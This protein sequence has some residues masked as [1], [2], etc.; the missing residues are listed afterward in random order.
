MEQ[1]LVGFIL[2]AIGGLNVVRPDI[3]LR[4]QV[5][6]QRTV[7]GARYEPSRRTY[8]IVRL[9]GAVFMLLGLVNITGA[10]YF[11]ILQQTGGKGEQVA[12]AD[13]TH[14][15]FI[16]AVDAGES[17]TLSFD[18]AVWLSGREGEDAAIAAGHC[19]EEE[20]SECLPNDYFIENA[21]P[22]AAPLP[23]SPELRVFMQTLYA[24]Q[25]SVTRREITT[26]QFT[27]LI[28]DAS[29]HWNKLPYT[30]TVEHGLVTLIEEV[31]IP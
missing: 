15:G 12:L 18:E 26:A 1:T 29:L 14:L 6:V 2:L 11:G 8:T 3:L 20:R 22:E 9:L 27:S 13:G 5:W 7:M 16:R 30:I 17:P 19:T 28:N 10:G 31:Y 21:S 25:E 4:F 24:E 23:A